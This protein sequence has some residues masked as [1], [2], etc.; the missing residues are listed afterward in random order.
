MFPSR[1]LKTD[2][3]PGPGSRPT[4]GGSARPSASLRERKRPSKTGPSVSAL[5]SSVAN[6]RT[7]GNPTGGSRAGSGR[8]SPFP[9]PC[10]S[11]SE[12]R[13]ACGPPSRTGGGRGTTTG[14]PPTVSTDGP[15]QS[16]PGCLPPRPAS[17]P[18]RGPWALPPNPLAP[19]LAHPDAG[20]RPRRGASGPV[21]GGGRCRGSRTATWLSPGRASLSAPPPLPPPPRSR[22]RSAWTVQGGGGARWTGLH[23]STRSPRRPP[24]IPRETRSGARGGPETD[25]YT[26]SSDS[27]C[28]PDEVRSFWQSQPHPP[29]VLPYL[30]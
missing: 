5:G 23:A 18:R 1:G 24:D 17:R 10:P 30:P 11:A 15:R 28:G 9:S 7:K 14:W 27:I 29:S 19:S 22:G 2:G 12:G 20:A 13:G 8:R 6:P 21:A 4:G 25:G 3:H 26:G 16:G